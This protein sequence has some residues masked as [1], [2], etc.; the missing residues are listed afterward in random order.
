MATTYS[1]YVAPDKTNLYPNFGLKLKNNNTNLLWGG[2]HITMNS[3][4]KNTDEISLR[5]ICSKVCMILNS[6][7]KWKPIDMEL[8]HENGLVMV[9]I[10]C[11]TLNKIAA[12]L[13]EAKLPVK[14]D[15]HVTLGL[16]SELPNLDFNDV[17]NYLQSLDWHL[18][19]VKKENGKVEWREQYQI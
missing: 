15:F 13:A 9:N 11:C 1:L 6:P 2:P 18:T 4:I 7:T 14:T 12:V 10:E 3:F 17:I 19:I 5:E 16:E 8:V